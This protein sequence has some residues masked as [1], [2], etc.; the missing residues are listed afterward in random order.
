MNILEKDRMSV[1][2]WIVLFFWAIG[3]VFEMVYQGIVK[4]IKNE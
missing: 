2:G 1:F 3:I 4:K